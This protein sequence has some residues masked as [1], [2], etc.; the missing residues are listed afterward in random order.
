MDRVVPNQT[1][2]QWWYLSK[3]RFLRVQTILRF[4]WENPNRQLQHNKAVVAVVQ[5]IILLRLVLQVCIIVHVKINT[6]PTP[7]ANFNN[8]FTGMWHHKPQH[9]YPHQQH[10]PY[11]QHYTREISLQMKTWGMFQRPIHLVCC[12][13]SD[14]ENV[15]IHILSVIIVQK[16]AGHSVYISATLKEDLKNKPKRMTQVWSMNVIIH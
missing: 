4:R 2:F 15:T 1:P 11:H 3:H 9:L 7:I 5:T 6:S 16:K 12:A 10:R 14:T 13:K 8:F